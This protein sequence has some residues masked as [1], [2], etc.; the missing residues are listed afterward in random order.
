[1]SARNGDKSRFNRERKQKIARRKR[2]QELLE[3]TAKGRKP[4]DNTVRAQ[5]RSV[6]A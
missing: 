3:R 1:M 6:S 2:N 4:A 5:T